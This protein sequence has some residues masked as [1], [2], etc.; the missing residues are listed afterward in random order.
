MPILNDTDFQK[1]QVALDIEATMKDLHGKMVYSFNHV[2]ALVWNHPTLTPQ[3][4]FD[5]LGSRSANLFQLA[6]LCAST[7]EA[8]LPN[9]PLVQPTY[10]YTINPDGT[11]TVGAPV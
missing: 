11:V 8:A 9:T 7:I 10:A 3:Q 1:A 5:G 6:S 4:V 2:A